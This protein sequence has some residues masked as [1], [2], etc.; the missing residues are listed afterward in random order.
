MTIPRLLIIS[1]CDD[2]IASSGYE[3]IPPASSAT[4]AFA[5]LESK[6]SL[7]YANGVKLLSLML[8]VTS[9][10]KILNAGSS[11]STNKGLLFNILRTASFTSDD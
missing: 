3:S 7:L 8:Q 5:N 10:R 1:I 4:N 11:S 6:L 9:L 2:L